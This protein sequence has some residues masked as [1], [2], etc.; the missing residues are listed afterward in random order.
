MLVQFRIALLATL[1]AILA[2]PALADARAAG[3]VVQTSPAAGPSPKEPVQTRFRCDGGRILSVAFV[4]RG[5]LLHAVADVGQ[6]T[7]TLKLEPWTGVGTGI[8]WSD[9][10]TELSWTPG[11]NILWSQGERHLHCGRAGHEH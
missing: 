3:A 2:A 4:T 5:G 7:H 11:V 10:K 6:E 8:L 1:F 9:G